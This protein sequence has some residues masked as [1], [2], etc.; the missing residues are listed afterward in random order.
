[1]IIGKLSSC[2]FLPFGV[3]SGKGISFVPIPGLCLFISCLFECSLRLCSQLE[4]TRNVLV[5]L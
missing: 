2:L 5:S 4:V 3:Y 1:M